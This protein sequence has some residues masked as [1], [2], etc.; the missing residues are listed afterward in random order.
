LRHAQNISDHWI[1]VYDSW[2]LPLSVFAVNSA[3]IVC[4]GKTMRI[5]SALLALSATLLASTASLAADLGPR[6]YTKAPG[7]TATHGPEQI[8]LVNDHQYIVPGAGGV[9]EILNNAWV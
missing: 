7:A 5:R 9:G 3:E 6:T 8:P 2:C 4:G 1:F